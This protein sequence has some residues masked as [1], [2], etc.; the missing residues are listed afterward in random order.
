MI[1]NFDE[2]K[3]QIF[4]KPCPFCGGEA[5]V[6]EIESRM[7]RF[8]AVI[9]CQRCGANLDWSQEFK[10]SA[11]LAPTGVVIKTV[12]IPVS[13]SPFDAWNRR[14][15]NTL[16]GYRAKVTIFDEAPAADVVEV[17]TGQWVTKYNEHGYHKECSVCGARW[18]LDSVKH[19]CVETPRC[20][21]CG[22]RLEKEDENNGTD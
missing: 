11:K 13:L 20:Y 10:Y 2:L 14:A 8:R 12:R 21:N 6:E 17:V 9:K 19:I 7:D 22:A 4:L 15:E 18:M 5:K 16:D 1:G 3:A